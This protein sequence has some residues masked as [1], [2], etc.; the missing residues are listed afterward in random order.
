[1]RADIDLRVEQGVAEVVIDRPARRNA[2]GPSSMRALTEAFGAIGADG[3][4]G[5]VLVRG[6]GGFLCSGLDLTEIDLGAPPLD[7]WAGVHLALAGL[8][9]PVVGALGTG[10]VNAG[11]ALALGCDL[12]VAG[13]SSFLEIKEVTMGMTP[14]VNLAWLTRRVSPA[15]ALQMVLTGRRY[16]AE[17]LHELGVVV[18][19]VADDQ[20][21]AAAT[22]LARALAGY[23]RDAAARTKRLLAA[24]TG[25]DR[26]FAAV[27]ADVMAQP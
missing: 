9:V 8:T 15:V 25:A 20:V 14:P 7:L 11:A 6:A 4:V 13:T 24:A 23:P 3:S 22:D 19:V 27:L 10:A 16:G 12:L 5:A 17:R 2:L 21:V 1:M 26:S 18:D